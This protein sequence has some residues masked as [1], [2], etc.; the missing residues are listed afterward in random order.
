MQNLVRQINIG[1]AL[2]YRSCLLFSDR[3]IQFSTLQQYFPS[4]DQLRADSIFCIFLDGF[5]FLLYNSILHY[6]SS[7]CNRHSSRE[8]RSEAS[9]PSMSFGIFSS[10]LQQLIQPTAAIGKRSVCFQISVES[11]KIVLKS[12]TVMA[13][14]DIVFAAPDTSS[15]C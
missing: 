4:S 15:F 9:F 7:A 13:A 11:V 1:L 8:E 12:G 2:S 14:S 10:S 6:Q 3:R 5:N